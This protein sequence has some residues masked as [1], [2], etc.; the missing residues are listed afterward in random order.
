M[1]RRFDRL[2]LSS[3]E[4][5]K[6]FEQRPADAY[7][8]E[9]DLFLSMPDGIELSRSFLKIKSPQWRRKLVE[10]AHSLA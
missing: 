1:G 2:F 9:I 6:L 3:W 8:L 5:K 4:A 10:L 7:D